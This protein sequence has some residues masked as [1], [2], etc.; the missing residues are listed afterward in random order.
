MYC[1]NIVINFGKEKIIFCM[2]IAERVAKE[3]NT[4]N[5][6]W[7]DLHGFFFCSCAI[8]VQLLRSCFNST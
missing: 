7:A 8:N 3:R 6:D 2:C 5:T 1:I 4:D